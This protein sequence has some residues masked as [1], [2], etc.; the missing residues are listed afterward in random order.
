MSKKEP[1]QIQSTYGSPGKAIAG[2]NDPGEVKFAIGVRTDGMICIEFERP[3]KFF[4][5]DPESAA[6]MGV[7][8][9]DH[10]RTARALKGD[11]IMLPRVG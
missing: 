10:A 4:A 11:R 8:M 5:L 6:K 3:C 9:I 2:G 7:V 1:S